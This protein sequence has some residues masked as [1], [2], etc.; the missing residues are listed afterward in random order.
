M[1]VLTT[2]PEEGATL[3]DLYSALKKRFG[4]DQQSELVKAQLSGHKRRSQESMGE[5]AHDIH[6]SVGIAHANIPPEYREELALDHFLRA[7]GGTDVGVMLTAWRP[8]TLQ[9]AADAAACWEA[10]KAS[11][12]GAGRHV[13]AIRQVGPVDDGALGAGAT[14]GDW[15]RIE[16]MVQN[17]VDNRWA[18]SGTRRSGPGRAGDGPSGGT[19]IRNEGGYNSTYRRQ[20][21]YQR[22]YNCGAR[23]HLRQEC[24]GP[25]REEPPRRGE[26]RPPR[27]PTPPRANRESQAQPSP[28]HQSPG[29]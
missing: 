16:R 13:V 14:L 12:G 11:F 4:M 21:P 25:R 26:P 6:R 7:I 9:R 3:E 27:P 8:K 29:H 20:T 24:N 19:S 18:R 2:V 15:A 23:D 28:P 22:C 17:T 1:E 5:L 10:A